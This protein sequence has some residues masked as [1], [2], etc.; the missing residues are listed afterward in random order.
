MKLG[1]A[2]VALGLLVALGASAQP[3]ADPSARSDGDESPAASLQSRG[4]LGATADVARY[5]Y[6]R[7]AAALREGRT[8]LYFSGYVWHASYAY[9]AERRRELNEQAWG[10]GLGRSIVDA[11]GNTHSLYFTVFRSSHFKPQ[12]NLGYSWLT[13]WGAPG[14]LR[15][16]LGYTVF[17]F[18]RTDI[19]GGL[20]IPGVLPLASI[21]YRRA[22]LLGTYLPAGHAAGNVAYLFG[23][24]DF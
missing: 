12:Y 21:R 8:D 24:F 1:A 14:A 10:A 9:T 18:S 23:R 19:Y 3:A 20:P 13:Y 15:A 16:G 5:K 6:E 11:G 7:S 22:E 17:L 2:A 4:L